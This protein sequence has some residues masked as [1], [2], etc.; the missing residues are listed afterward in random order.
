MC[1]CVS[2]S[3]SVS[4]LECEYVRVSVSGVHLVG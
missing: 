1:E 4:V 2:V 3:D